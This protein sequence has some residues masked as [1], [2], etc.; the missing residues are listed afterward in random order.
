MIYILIFGIVADWRGSVVV[1]EREINARKDWVRFWVVNV[2]LFSRK[3]FNNS[4]KVLSVLK[5][6]TTVYE[7]ETCAADVTYT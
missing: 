7:R 1:L 3:T 5:M 4:S 6:A 2:F